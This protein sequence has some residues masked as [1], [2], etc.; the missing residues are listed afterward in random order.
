MT[1]IHDSPRNFSLACFVALGF[2]WECVQLI[3]LNQMV[4]RSKQIKLFRRYCGQPLTTGKTTRKSC[5]PSVNLHIIKWFKVQ[6]AKHHSTWIMVFIP[7]G[8]GW[9]RFI[10]LRLVCTLERSNCNCK[11]QHS[12]SYRHSGFG[13][14]SHSKSCHIEDRRQSS[15]S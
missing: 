13:S 3:I 9:W 5:C 15:C 7:W 12:V 1:T 2:S 10:E 11:G 8:S 4:W 14:R 6:R